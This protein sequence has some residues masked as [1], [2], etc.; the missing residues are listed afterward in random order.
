MVIG[1]GGP[2]IKKCIQAKQGDTMNWISKCGLG[3]TICLSGAVSAQEIRWR[4]AA[5]PTGGGDPA[6]ATSQPAVTIKRPVPISP[7]SD[8]QNA[9]RGG[10]DIHKTSFAHT[11]FTPVVRAQDA[12]DTKDK[13][14]AKDDRLD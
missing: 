12:E 4:P 8:P 10:A 6:M 9:R 13:R 11:S 14:A 7:S 3:L 1:H 5:A 2:D